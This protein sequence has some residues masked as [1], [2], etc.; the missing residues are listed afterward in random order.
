MGVGQNHLPSPAKFN[1]PR[2]I[3]GGLQQI[4]SVFAFY[5]RINVLHKRKL[6]ILLSHMA[7]SHHAELNR[8]YSLITLCL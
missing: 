2:K 8:G 7:F 1:P 3:L 4:K 5:K 6:S